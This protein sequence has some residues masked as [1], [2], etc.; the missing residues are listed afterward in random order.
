MGALCVRN[1]LQ[2]W[3]CKRFTELVF[4]RNRHSLSLLGSQGLSEKLGKSRKKIS[5]VSE[6]KSVISL[7]FVHHSRC[8]FNCKMFLTMNV[9]FF[10]K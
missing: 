9:N 7:Q 5:S 8:A 6:K 4:F 2:T 3:C 1:C 10:Y